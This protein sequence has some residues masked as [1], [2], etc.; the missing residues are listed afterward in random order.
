MALTPDVVP[1]VV[2]VPRDLVVVMVQ[3]R[4]EHDPRAKAKQGS[5]VVNKQAKKIVVVNLKALRMEKIVVLTLR[6][7]TPARRE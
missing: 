1:L 2:G 6:S 5:Q 7:H 4:D 3:E